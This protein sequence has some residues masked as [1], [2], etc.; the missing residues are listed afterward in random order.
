MG[1]AISTGSTDGQS[2]RC[3]G[4][5]TEQAT[6]VS[7]HVQLIIS[8]LTEYHIILCINFPVGSFHRDIVR[9]KS[10]PVAAAEAAVARHDPKKQLPAEETTTTP[11]PAEELKMVMIVNEEL[12]MGKGKIAAQCAHAAVGAVELLTQKRQRQ[13]LAQ[14]EMCGQAKIALRAP[15]WMEMKE[16]MAVADHLGVPTFVVQDAG[17]TQVDPGSRTVLALG[18]APRSLIDKCSGELKLL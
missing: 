2:F 17:R 10:A 14:W 1:V 6:Q 13:V 4:E 9:R 11:L 5:A 18:P 8:I 16:I 12:K 7:R 3:M 15:S